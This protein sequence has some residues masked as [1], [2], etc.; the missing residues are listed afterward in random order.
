MKKKIPFFT[1]SSFKLIPLDKPLDVPPNVT[2]LVFTE[3]GNIKKQ[4]AP[5]E[6]VLNDMDEISEIIVQ[7]DNKNG[8]II[9]N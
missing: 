7:T 1:H 9:L 5:V 4:I 6:Y 3:Q 8:Y 2:V